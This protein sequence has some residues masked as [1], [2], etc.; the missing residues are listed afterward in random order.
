MITLFKNGNIHTMDEVSTADAFVVKDNK[1]AYVGTESGAKN[2]LKN[3]NFIEMDLKGH[4]VMPGFNDSHMHFLY[5][6]KS[7]KNINLTGVRS[8]EEIK[9]RIKENLERREPCDDS[10]VEGEGWNQD[11]FIEE[12]RFPNKFDLDSVTGDIPAVIMRTCFHIGVLNSAAL[13]RVGLNKETAKEYGDLVE[14]LSDGEPNG[15]IKEGLVSIVKR[16]IPT[17]KLETLKNL[18]DEA[19]HYA[20]AQGITSIQTDDIGYTIGNYELLFQAFKELDEEG[21]LNIRLGEQC[22]ITEIDKLK[23]F[24][25]KGFNRGYG[26]NKYR[27][28]CI[29]LLCDGSLGARTAALRNPYNDAP[30]TKGI[31]TFTQDELNQLVLLPHKNN[32]PVAIHGIGDRAIEMA[33]D[34]IEY[35]QKNDPA[36]YPRHGIVHCQVTD[37]GILRRIQKLNVLTYVQPIFV[38]FDM[39][40]V[41]D[42]VGKELAETSYAWKSM[43]DK[44]IHT[45]LGTDCPVERFDTMPNIYLAVERKNTIREDKKVYLPNEKLTIDEALKAYTIEGAYASGEEHIKGS[46]TKGKL[47]DFILLN[48]DLYNLTDNEEILNTKV[49]ETYVDGELV[50]RK[51]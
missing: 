48:K 7:L 21:K 47:A 22:L 45:S 9:G 8:I 44:G 26:N 25:K 29:K 20:L 50:Y 17:I 30:S 15:V 13:K 24:F 18:M 1:F 12:K 31:E 4:F 51:Q 28:S 33:L 14:T 37:E 11:F 40:I 38:D 34:A 39:Y 35:A 41:Y 6:A 36:H 10:W 16:H 23:T 19:Q 43:I 27:V 42:R 5:F 2:F 46:I 49:L 3:Q 32:C